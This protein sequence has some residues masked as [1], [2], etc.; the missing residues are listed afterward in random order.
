MNLNCSIK[1]LPERLFSQEQGFS[2]SDERA[3]YI[4]TVFCGLAIYTN[5]LENRLAKVC[6]NCLINS[7]MD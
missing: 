5:N 1:Q 6:F 2:L 7:V 4:L 3:F